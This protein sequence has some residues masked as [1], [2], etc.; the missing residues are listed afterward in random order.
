MLWDRHLQTKHGEDKAYSP[1]GIY[2]PPVYG[3]GERNAFRP[4]QD[5]ISKATNFYP[6]VHIAPGNYESVQGSPGNFDSPRDLTPMTYANPSIPPHITYS[7]S[8]LRNILR[9]YL[10]DANTYYLVLVHYTAVKR[11]VSLNAVPTSAGILTLFMP[12]WLQ[13]NIFATLKYV[14]AM[15]TGC[16]VGL[17]GKN[18]LRSICETSTTEQFH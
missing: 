17:R 16:T 10:R 13:R 1:F 15:R 18:I 12:L 9:L 6:T 11:V 4:L 3:E 5:A 14:I 7:L 8:A 2:M